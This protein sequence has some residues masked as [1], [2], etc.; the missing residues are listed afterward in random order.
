MAEIWLGKYNYKVVSVYTHD[1][2]RCVPDWRN[3]YA[4]M[5]MVLLLVL[6]IGLGRVYG[7][8]SEV[9]LRTSR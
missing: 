8:V 9:W 4:R 7:R 2:S 6:C 5:A 1:C 3:Y